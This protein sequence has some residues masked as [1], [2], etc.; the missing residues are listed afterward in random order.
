MVPLDSG[1]CTRSYEERL[2]KARSAAASQDRVENSIS[3]QSHSCEP[4]S[5]C[6]GTLGHS[7]GMHLRYT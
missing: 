2:R 1:L 7:G 6:Y 4:H 3:D 5:T